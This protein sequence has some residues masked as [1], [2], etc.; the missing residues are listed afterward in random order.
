MT[1]NT[2]SP[3]TIS[4]R[5]ALTVLG[6][7]GIGTAAFQQAL[8]AQAAKSKGVTAAVIKESEQIAGITLSDA[9]RERVARS[10]NRSLRDYA[11]LRKLKLDNGVSPAVTF[12]PAPWLPPNDGRR[13]ST[14]S[15]TERAAPKLPRSDE[16]LA[17]L[18]V[19]EL[20]AL[21]R[22]RKV[23]STRL[24]KLYLSRLKKYDPALKFVVN[25]TE[26]LALKQAARADAEISAGRYRGAL[27]GIPWGAKD[28]MA[29]PGYPTTWGAPQFK[30]QVIDEPATVYR[31][32]EAAG[33]VLV[34]KLS[35]GA[36]AQGDRWF[37][38]QTKC[39]WYPK[40][41]SSGSSAGS[42]SATAAGCVGFSIG[43]ETLGS[44]ISPCRR[45]GT[46]G[47]RPT[48]G[49]VSRHGCM[50]LSWSMDKVGPITRSVEDCA[51]V[52]G[53][54]HG[55]D[56]RD[57][58]AVDRPYEWPLKRDLSA[59]KVGYFAGRTPVEKRTDLKILRELGVQLLP[60]ELP[61]KNPYY[62]LRMILYTEAGAVFDELT[63]TDNLEGINTWK[64]SFRNAQFV[65]AVEYLRA[66]RV[67]S[68]V[69]RDMEETMS[70]V[71]CY[72]GGNDLTL[73]N[74]TGHPSAVMPMGFRKVRNIELPY[75]VTFTG[76]LYGEST[77]LAVAHAF[78]QKLTAHLR[79]PPMERLL[80]PPAKKA[81]QKPDTK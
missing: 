56:G 57:P 42:G 52:F 14:V 81:E 61:K 3:K 19:T 73:T 21:V 45:N 47:L 37:G 6:G 26:K 8:A 62:P 30:E 79:R 58:S 13:K 71:D 32:L 40:I 78:Q 72:V 29:V 75:S 1:E 50:T 44:I 20:A 39:P 76:R 41:G 69:M 68:L 12:D 80:E 66:N 67:R 22:T 17:F 63:R 77:L 33:A 2:N 65:P 55:F 16:D 46:S 15:M 28:L 4:R 5:D 35:M 59:L 60:I 74:L 51:L 24:T 36:L 34:A 31:R 11:S 9:D 10:M 38:G 70:K 27:H 48:F 49:R 53:A 7:L 25:L 23:T 18:P 54:I 43:T 64:Q